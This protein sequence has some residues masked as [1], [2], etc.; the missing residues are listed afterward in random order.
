MD[1]APEN[2]RRFWWRIVIFS[3]IAVGALAIVVPNFIA[4]RPSPLSFRHACISNLLQIDGAKEQWAADNKAGLGTAVI[5][6]QIAEYIKGG[7]L[8]QCPK[9]GKYII[10]KVGELPRCSISDHAIPPRE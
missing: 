3:A 2:R 7:R 1:Y 6:A 8:P 5:E 9:G 10:G 4:C